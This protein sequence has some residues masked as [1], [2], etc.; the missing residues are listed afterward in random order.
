MQVLKIMD[1]IAWGGFSLLLFCGCNKDWLE[2]KPNLNL[3]VPTTAQ[4]YQA[5]LDNDNNI[6]NLSMPALGEI[7]SGDFSISSA[8]WSTLATNMERYAY[9]W[10]AQIYRGETNIADWNA[11]YQ[12]VFTA[13]IVLEGV[14]HAAAHNPSSAWDNVQGSALF[15]RSWSFYALSQAFAGPYVASSGQSD[16]G[17]PLR[18]KSDINAPSVRASLKDTYQQVISDLL[19]AK[20][21]LPATAAYKTRPS[22]AAVFGLLARVYLSMEDYRNAFLNA[23]SCL[24]LREEVLDYNDLDSTAARPLPRMNSEVIFQAILNNFGIF[25]N[26]AFNV[27][28]ELYQSYAQNDLRRGMFFVRRGSNINYKGSYYQ[29]KPLF[30]GLA[31]DEMLLIR[32]ECL[33]RKGDAVAAVKDLNTL[34]E[35]RWI[36]GTYSRYENNSA[37]QVLQKVIE[38]RRKELCFRGLRWT[39][40]RRL[41]TDSRFSRTLK[42]VI[43]EQTYWLKPQGAGYVLPIPDDVIRLSGI[44][45]NPR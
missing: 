19:K 3:V 42:R 21:L 35:K 22:K 37:D 25:S 33:A 31:T 7:G 20:G 2:A 32:A 44:A 10:D 26:A 28:A 23:D 8:A 5:I 24:Q 34:L 6:F 9:L 40:L 30:C 14:D 39:D 36:K 45:Q 41:N 16:L 4:D 43:N 12:A 17:I 1:R 38:E 29:A 15:Y 18:V 27:D 11:P 13:N